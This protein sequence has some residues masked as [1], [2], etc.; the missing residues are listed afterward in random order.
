MPLFNSLNFDVSTI[1]FFGVLLAVFSALIWWVIRKRLKGWWMPILQVIDIQAKRLPKLQWKKPPLIP[2]LAFMLS[3]IAF[4]FLL[5]KP[6]T[7]VQIS[8]KNKEITQHIF[9]DLSASMQTNY[10]L[11]ELK[12]Q[13]KGLWLK[14]K[15]R[16]VINL[17][18]S[19]YPDFRSPGDE[20]SLDTFLETLQFHPEGLKLGS[21]FRTYNN[22]YNQ[23]DDLFIISDND[24]NTWS[25]FD[26]QVQGTDRQVYTFGESNHTSPY[27]IFISQASYLSVAT[28]Q[29]MTWNIEITRSGKLNEA[30]TAQISARAGT[31]TLETV[32][33]TMVPGQSKSI[34][35]MSWLKEKVQKSL[36]TN[37]AD[38]QPKLTFLIEGISDAIALD[39][40]FHAFL[41]GVKKNAVL[42]SMPQGEIALENPDYFMT[43]SLEILDFR[44]ERVDAISK[45]TK[46]LLKFPY[47]FIY[48]STRENIDRS[49]PSDLIK[50][51]SRKA[52][53]TPPKIWLIPQS[54]TPSYQNLCHCF[55]RL[56]ITE[57]M[58][59][60][61]AKYCDDAATKEQYYAVIK[62]L[63]GKQVGGDLDQQTGPLAYRF[64]DKSQNLDIMAFGQPLFPSPLTGIT[65]TALPQMIQ[66]VLQWQGVI[67]KSD[68]QV[69]SQW[70]RMEDITRTRVN[71][72]K[73]LLSNVAIGESQLKHLDANQLPPY[74]R[75]DLAQHSSSGAERQERNPVPWLKLIVWMVLA[76]IAFEL[77]WFSYR[78]TRR[79]LSTAAILATLLTAGINDCYAKIAITTFK[80]N[81]TNP[82]VSQLSKTVSDRTSIDLNKTIQNSDTWADKSIT[83]WLWVH[84][85]ESI[86]DKKGQLRPE[87]VAWIKRGGF[88]ILEDVSNTLE[89]EK[90]TASL[91]NS[92][93]NQPQWKPI[94]P[95]HEIMRSFHLLDSLPICN[96]KLW[97]GLHFDQ[98]LAILAIPYRF[99]PTLLE[100]PKLPRC[101]ANTT[102][103]QTDR[104]FI[105]IL[106]VA[107]TTDYKKDQ[108]HLPEILKRLRK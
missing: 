32:E 58:N 38:L 59:Q 49:C 83:P 81:L 54:V 69:A 86:T 51:R 13:V 33:F 3:A 14:I 108:I 75:T 44:V 79:F 88:L 60:G 65:H 93:I 29:R 20:D 40:Q 30:I 103:E 8:Q 5:L 101:T 18:S 97:Q 84:R 37:T 43:K 87:F 45:A 46:N 106:M 72:S 16:G 99:L 90:L 95:D 55:T 66:S 94:P 28:S 12:N 31:T 53:I 17:S 56:A 22:L 35:S 15:D 21:W 50:L 67:T 80:Q 74:W 36:A 42:I 71:D 25:D 27:N 64:E 70:P 102:R 6:A 100:Q 7:L 48:A 105:N 63:G 68:S 52:K 1:I 107:L 2:F 47:W 89:L 78:T 98:R 73:Q 4:C 9:V 61:K 76:S 85:I 39:N 34:V 41:L 10:D 19:R 92:K 82:S 91:S 26:W 96:K 23:V 24:L 77:L 62:G 57:S 11:Q 104:I